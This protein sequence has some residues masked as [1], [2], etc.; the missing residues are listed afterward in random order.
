[1]L[2]G[3]NGN[4][5]II[6]TQSDIIHNT[7]KLVRQNKFKKWDSGERRVP[8]KSLRVPFWVRVP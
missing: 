4:A 7:E 6:S 1:V 3:S 5:L 8:K 2:F